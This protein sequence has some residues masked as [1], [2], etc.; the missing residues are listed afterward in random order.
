MIDNL[1]IVKRMSSAVLKINY[2]TI[3]NILGDG[4]I[5]IKKKNSKNSK[6]IFEKFKIVKY[7]ENNIITIENKL[8]IIIYLY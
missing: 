2:N 6:H 8:L 3:Y 7:E 5:F 4:I 1:L